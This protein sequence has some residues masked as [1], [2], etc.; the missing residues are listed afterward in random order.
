MTSSMKDTREEILCDS[1]L[2]D[3]FTDKN[4]ILSDLTWDISTINT[5]DWT[6]KQWIILV[7]FSR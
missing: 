1:T 5:E 7:P 6:V 3:E 4:Q 2:I